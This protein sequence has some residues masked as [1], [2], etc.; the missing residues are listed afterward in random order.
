MTDC[1]CK[2]VPLN[3]TTQHSRC[4]PVRFLGRRIRMQLIWRKQKY[5][6]NCVT[7]L[8]SIL[9]VRACIH[10]HRQMDRRHTKSRLFVFNG[11]QIVKVPRSLDS[12]HL[13]TRIIRVR[14]RVRVTLLL[15]VYRQSVRLGAKLLRVT[16]RCTANQFVLAPSS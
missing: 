13:V 11:C 15:A 14:V 8:S 6:W 2:G 9:C 3:R 12:I 4:R 16:R 7:C 1:N 10:T 5:I